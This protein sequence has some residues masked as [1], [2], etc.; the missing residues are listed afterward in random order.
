[1]NRQ[2]PIWG[3]CVPAA[4]CPAQR[5]NTVPQPKGGQMY[6][7][8]YEAKTPTCEKHCVP[9]ALMAAAGKPC[10]PHTTHRRNHETRND[11]HPAPDHRGAR[12][13]PTAQ[14]GHGG[15]AASL[16]PVAEGTPHHHAAPP[17]VAAG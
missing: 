13:D 7:I 3:I 15:C 14:M 11:H 16:E 2:S 1:M 12:A 4:L 5:V 6:G 8:D 10:P 17:R 9:C